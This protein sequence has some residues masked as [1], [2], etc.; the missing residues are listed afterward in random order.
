MINA[1]KDNYVHNIIYTKTHSEILKYH[2]LCKD[3]KSIH[4]VPL[5]NFSMDTTTNDT[6]SSQSYDFTI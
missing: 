1:L 6:Y 4:N 3:Y 5:N 2:I